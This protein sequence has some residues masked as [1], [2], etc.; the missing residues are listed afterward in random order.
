MKKLMLSFVLAIAAITGAV[1]QN[2]DDVGF[3]PRVGLNLSNIA[4]GSHKDAQEAT[5][6]LNPGAVV[7]L[8]INIP[9]GKIMSIQPEVLF[10]QK[11]IRSTAT[12]GIFKDSY[13]A[14]VDNYVEIPLLAKARLGGK[15]YGMLEAG[16][17]AGVWLNRVDKRQLV[18]NGNKGDVVKDKIELKDDGNVRDNRFDAGIAFGTGFGFGAGSG[19]VEFDIRYGMGFVDKIH[20]ENG[21]PDGVKK[22]LNRNFGISAMFLF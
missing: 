6:N 17:Y 22:L 21:R 18:I 11:G 13:W 12:K 1:A 14:Y 19:N 16:P 10:A 20:Y 5:D 8:A 3:G 7:G 4:Y 9:F 2:P 15:F